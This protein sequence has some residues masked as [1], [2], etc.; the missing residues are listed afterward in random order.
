MLRAALAFNATLSQSLHDCYSDEGIDVMYAQCPFIAF[1]SWLKRGLIL[2]V[3][4]QERVLALHIRRTF[5]QM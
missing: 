3:V 5:D 1:E 2:E 4:M